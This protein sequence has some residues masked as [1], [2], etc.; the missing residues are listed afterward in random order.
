MYYFERCALL[1]LA[2]F[3]NCPLNSKGG[4]EQVLFNLLR[5]CGE[6]FLFVCEDKDDT[7]APQQSHFKAAANDPARPMLGYKIHTTQM[8]VPGHFMYVLYIY[9]YA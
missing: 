1:F 4:T 8:S 3:L 7:R 5:F 9:I 6:T 2:S